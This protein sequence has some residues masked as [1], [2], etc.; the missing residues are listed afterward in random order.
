[1]K[2]QPNTPV[3]NALGWHGRL[4]ERPKKWPKLKP[5]PLNDGTTAPLNDD[6]VYVQWK[7]R[8]NHPSG[9]VV[10]ARV[11]SLIVIP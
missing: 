5:L 1:M 2:P 6:V 11:D 4:V 9:D 8:K 10:S 7:E 3:T